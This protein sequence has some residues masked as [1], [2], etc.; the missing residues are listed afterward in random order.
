MCFHMYYLL[1]WILLLSPL[2]RWENVCTNE[3]TVACP[4]TI[5]GKHPCIVLVNTYAYFIIQIPYSFS[6]KNMALHWQSTLWPRPRTA[7]LKMSAGIRIIWKACENKDHKAP[8]SVRVSDLVDLSVAPEFAFLTSSYV[9]RMLLV[10]DHIL[11]TTSLE[12]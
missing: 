3:K 7:V 4:R 11:R 12:F 5:N 8:P 9:R 10:R 6:D 1:N 2:N